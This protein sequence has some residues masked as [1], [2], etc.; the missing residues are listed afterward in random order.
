MTSVHWRADKDNGQPG[1]AD[2]EAATR[3]V[4]TRKQGM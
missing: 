3:S 2:L 4:G 1:Q